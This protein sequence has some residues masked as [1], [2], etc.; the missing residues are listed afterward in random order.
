MSIYGRPGDV[1]ADEQ[2]EITVVFDVEEGRA[3]EPAVGSLGVGRGGDVFEVALAVVAKEIA[4]ADGRHVEIG[5]AV[6][7]IIAH[8]HSLAVKRLV[9]PGLP[10][11]VLEMSLAVVA[12]EGLGGR[13]LDLVAGPV[14]GV[15]EEQVLVAVAVIVEKGHA[16]AHRLGQELVAE[17]AVVVDEVDA[18]FLGDVD[19]LDRRATTRLVTATGR[20]G[21][22]ALGSTGLAVPAAAAAGHEQE[23]RQLSVPDELRQVMRRS[24]VGTPERE[25][26]RRRRSWCSS[27]RVGCGRRDRRSIPG[28]PGRWSGW[29]TIDWAFM[30]AAGSRLARQGEGPALGGLVGLEPFV[31]LAVRDLQGL[32]QRG[33]SFGVGLRPFPGGTEDRRPPRAAAPVATDSADA[34]RP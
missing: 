26:R 31:Q 4:A 29:I 25:P 34:D 2:I 1:V 33:Q 6:V 13:R 3:G 5:I 27:D 14:R 8:G 30:L 24:F 28:A 19:E 23:S 10:G 15:D 32:G 9:E 21:A 17:G 20:T 11:D 16:R 22:T 12:V 18:G 7:V